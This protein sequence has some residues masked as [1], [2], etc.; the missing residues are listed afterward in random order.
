M[1][2]IKQRQFKPYDL[3]I[4][5]GIP[6]LIP[7][8]LDTVRGLA[9]LLLVCYHVVGGSSARGLRLPLTSDWHYAMSSFE[10]IRMPI[11]TMLSGFLYARFRATSS[12]I[13]D[14]LVKK[15]RRIGVPLLVATT[16]YWVLRRATVG[17]ERPFLTALFW[18]Y[19]HLWYL[20]SLITLFFVVAVIDALFMPTPTVLFFIAIL[21]ALISAVHPD[22]GTLF[23]AAGTIYLAP[24]FVFGIVVAAT[25]R[26]PKDRILGIVFGVVAGTILLLQQASLN[27][28]IA[29][30]AKQDFLATVCGVA[31]CLFLLQFMQPVQLLAT[32]GEGSYTV[33]LWHVLFA[34]ATRMALIRLGFE[35][36]P[37]LFAV[38]VVSGIAGPLML[39]RIASYTALLSIPLLGIKPSSEGRRGFTVERGKSIKTIKPRALTAQRFSNTRNAP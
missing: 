14:F 33:Y 28:V 29:P 39:H 5:A 27:G 16:V 11:F 2:H 31:S 9:C 22:V 37:L 26:L 4:T 20:Q 38:S 25:P 8:N 30:I 6:V 23:S 19:E 24:Y 18:S 3:E 34:A 17:D 13:K 10:F 7:D 36:S 1:K 21:L 12:T 35:A 32:I 15:T